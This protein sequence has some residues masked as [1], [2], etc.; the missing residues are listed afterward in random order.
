MCE[1]Y[2]IIPDIIR[3]KPWRCS[4]CSRVLGVVERNGSRQPVLHVLWRAKIIHGEIPEII[5]MDGDIICA[6]NG[7]A[8]LRC[9]VCGHTRR[10][11][12]ED[13]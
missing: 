8:L 5:C 7:S 13:A 3:G 4:H 6:V 12:E 9:P 11:V 1:E 2:K 10:W